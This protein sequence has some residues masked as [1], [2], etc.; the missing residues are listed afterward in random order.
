MNFVA[1]TSE[2]MRACV[3]CD[4]GCDSAIIVVVC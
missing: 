4:A 2:Y 1:T 3:R